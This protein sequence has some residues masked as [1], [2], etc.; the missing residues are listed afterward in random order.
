MLES[1]GVLV[2]DDQEIDIESCW[3]DDGGSGEG[4]RDRE[5]L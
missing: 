2:R 5:L 3:R 1:V 4:G